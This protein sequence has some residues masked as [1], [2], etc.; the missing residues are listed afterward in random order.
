MV[1]GRDWRNRIRGQMP[2]WPLILPVYSPPKPCHT[3]MR[4][5]LTVD[6]V[7]TVQMMVVAGLR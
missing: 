1:S 2:L 4:I 6:E 3:I 7:F 5:L